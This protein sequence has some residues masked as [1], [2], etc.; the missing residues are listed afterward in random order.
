MLSVHF[1]EFSL[2]DVGG[3]RNERR[4]WI[5]AFDNVTAVIF[6]AA[7]S[8]Y[9]QVCYEDTEKNRMVEA[10]ELFESIAAND[11]F[12]NIPIILFLNKVS[13]INKTWYPQ[14]SSKLSSG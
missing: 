4:K 9:D 7:L 11:A 5:H 3:Q 12:L 14:K 10:I 2:Y 8:E 1:Q 13:L 6:V